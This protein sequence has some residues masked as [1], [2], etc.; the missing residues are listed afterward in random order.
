VQGPGQADHFLRLGIA[1]GYSLDT[2][3]LDR[4]YFERQRLL[5][6]DRFVTRTPRERALSQQQATALNEAYETLKDPLPRA[7]YLLNLLCAEARPEGCHL[8]NDQELLTEAL[9][10]REALAEADTPE[11][12]R[13]LA[14]RTG[15]DIELCVDALSAA[16]AD[17]DLE[18][19][20]YLSTRLKYLRKLA[21]D[22]RSRRLELARP[23]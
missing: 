23:A 13:T 4:R 14:K 15:Q 8:V 11:A 17:D 16:F 3:V 18:R 10:L 20:S 21:D 6:P 2:G 12:V 5:H 7:V 1:R 9:E 19:A 22:C